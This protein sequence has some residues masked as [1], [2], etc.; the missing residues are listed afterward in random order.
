MRLT[1]TILAFGFLAVLS[2]Y[3]HAAVQSSVESDYATPE[4]EPKGTAY[5]PTFVAGGPSGSDV[6]EGALPVSSS[7]A[8]GIEDS[9]GLEALTDGRVDTVYN[10]G[11]AGAATHFAYATG[12]EG[13]TAT[14]MLPS[15]YDLSSI[16]VFGGW[17]DSGRDGQ[18][19]DILTSTDGVNFTT[20]VNYSMPTDD[21]GYGGPVSHRVEFTEDTLPY[22][23][24]GVTHLRF[25]WHNGEAGRYTGYTE[26]DVYG[27]AVPEPASVTLALL[28]GLAGCGAA[29]RR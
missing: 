19:Y 7:G 4:G 27:A 13:H 22:L 17:N 23:A 10:D 8:F 16:V 29:R 26:I 14:Y 28:L 3:S 24:T 1:P 5:N 15:P 12:E 18:V 6:L 21:D 9:L 11:S 25:D 20:L 2:A